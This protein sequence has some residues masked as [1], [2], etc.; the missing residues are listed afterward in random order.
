M[1]ARRRQRPPAGAPP[2]PESSRRGA[3]LWAG[4]VFLWALVCH[5]VYLRGDLLFDKPVSPLFFGDGVHFLAHARQLAAGESL[6]AALPFHP[7]LTAWLLTPL[8]RW[9]E[10][11]ELVYQASKLLMVVLNGATYAM[12]FLLLR[13]RTPLAGPICLLLPLCFGELLLSSVANSEAVYRPLLG[14]MLL[15]G[16]RW[17]LAGGAL[18]A[19]AALTRAEHLPVALLALAALAVALPARR[20]WA[21]ATAAS[22]VLLL[23]PYLL[24]A[25]RQLVAY[26]LEH[27][28]ELPAPLPTWVPISFYGPLNFALAQREEGIFFSRRTLPVA[29]EDA[30]LDPRHPIH[31]R[32]VTQG[33][34][35]G[36]AAIAAAPGRFLS[37]TL[38]KAGHSLQAVG[39]GWAWRDLP[40]G[41]EWL[42]PP[43]D[44]AFA[45]EPLYLA[46]ALAL[47]ALGAWS[48]RRDRPL[49][50]VGGLLL[51]YRLAVNVA[52]FPY[53]RSM[54]I[55]APFFLFLLLAGLQPLARGA[56]RRVLVTVLVLLGGFHL[57]TGWRT[58]DYRLSGERDA[59]G[60]IYDDRPVVVR[61]TGLR[62]RR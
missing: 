54:M 19:A 33:Y 34:R 23:V 30:T 12:T 2:A 61:F 14:G 47:A 22:C 49:L 40:K 39:Y 46:V 59:A 51:A 50:A 9:L 44:M 28:A 18:H 16:F 37:R 1:S 17:P 21:A 57:A 31:H 56:T 53:L 15:L 58:R 8:W 27:A 10:Q 26:N 20:R 41:R 52:F 60:V 3:V 55:A 43:I 6:G 11:P 36:F 35:L 45:R 48:L 38:A 7:P 29:A 4:G 62:E 5:L 24:T 32:Y 13:R 42:R 25:H